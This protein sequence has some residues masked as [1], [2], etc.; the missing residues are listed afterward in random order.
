M[1]LRRFVGETS[2]AVLDQ[3]RAVFGPDAIIVANRAWKTRGYQPWPTTSRMC[4]LR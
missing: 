1:K 2:R 4:G 3:V